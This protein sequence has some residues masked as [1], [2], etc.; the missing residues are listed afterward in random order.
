MTIVDH[1]PGTLDIPEH[2]GLDRAS[3][4]VYGPAVAPTPEPAPTTGPSPKPKRKPTIAPA[5]KTAPKSKPTTRPARRPAAAQPPTASKPK[6]KA[7][8]K[9]APGPATG[10][11]ASG[12]RSVL[13]LKPTPVTPVTPVAPV[14]RTDVLAPAEDRSD[15]AGGDVLPGQPTA[16]LK[17]DPDR[18]PELPT[19][20]GTGTAVTKT[21]PGAPLGTA[22]PAN[23]ATAPEVIA[24]PAVETTSALPV[25]ALWPAL[26]LLPVA[27]VVLLRRRR[28][29]RPKQ[30]TDDPEGRG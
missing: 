9:P 24:S 26:V 7:P 25:G 28:S 4:T 10:Q 5:L 2:R 29:E 23:A 30:A 20:A 18:P 22:A 19:K 21:P 6:A 3:I 27:F 8:S 13:D 1:D 14:V 11:G 15:P 16:W 12:W 17:P